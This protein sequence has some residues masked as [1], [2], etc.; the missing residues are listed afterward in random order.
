M[1]IGFVRDVIRNLHPCVT[2]TAH[3]ECNRFVFDF[4]GLFVKPC[5]DAFDHIHWRELGIRLIANVCFADSHTIKLTGFDLGI[6]IIL[7]D[8]TRMSHA[9]RLRDAVAIATKNLSIAFP[10]AFGLDGF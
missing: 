7:T 9:F 1:E 5:F 8:G 2:I 6:H 4:V 3:I 10:V